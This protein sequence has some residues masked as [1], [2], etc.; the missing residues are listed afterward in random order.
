MTLKA[1]VPAYRLESFNGIVPPNVS[2]VVPVYVGH[3]GC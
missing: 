3:C 2:M 1:F